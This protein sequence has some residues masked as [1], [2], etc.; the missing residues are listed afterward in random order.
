M[1][2]QTIYLHIIGIALLTA[3][4]GFFS[5]SE[6][7]L[8]ASS[9]PKL[10]DLEKQGHKAARRVRK[11]LDDP[12]TLL[13]ALLLGNNMVNI[14]ASAL[15]T[16]VMLDIFGSAGLAIATFGMTFLVLIFAEVLPKILAARYPE[17][18]AMMV[19]WPLVMLIKI[20]HPIT[21]LIRAITKV[22]IF[23]LGIKP[24]SDDPNFG[25]EDVRGAIGLGAAHGVLEKAEK[26]MLDS[27]LELDILTVNDVMT[28]RSK[29]ESINLNQPLPE[30]YQQISS[31]RYS[32]LPVW[33]KS[34]DNI[35][36]ILHVKDFYRAYPKT[37]NNMQTKE[38]AATSLLQQIMQPPYFVPESAIIAD[39]LLAFRRRRKHMGLVVDEYGDI[40]GI[41]TLED[42]LEE[43]VGDIEDEHDQNL[44]K[45]TREKDGRVIVSASYPVRDAN[46]EFDWALPD[47]DAVT[48]GGLITETAGEIP[49]VGQTF[50]INNYKLKVLGRKKQAVIRVEIQAS[51]EEEIA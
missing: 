50:E 16:K 11:L 41:V 7:A 49:Q 23:L 9:R 25:E 32:R 46:K 12:E 31:S 37:Q 29:I 1:D 13:A 27:I 22:L 45:F 2:E 18:M 15:A 36:G 14:A 4:S 33:E 26:Q 19:S 43:I 48:I 38:H 6:T 47:D 51:E 8:M 17:T 40:M 3:S 28:H 30:V 34:P 5:G 44:P 39:Q 24:K 21:V 10:H 20:T 35:I 42:I